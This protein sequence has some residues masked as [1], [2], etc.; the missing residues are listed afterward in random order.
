MN[1]KSKFL[2]KVVFGMTLILGACSKGT[3]GSGAGAGDS[4]LTLEASF[5]QGTNEIT[6]TIYF[7]QTLAKG[8]TIVLAYVEGAPPSDFLGNGLKSFALS[9]AAAS[10]KYRITKLGPANYSVW[11]R[12]DLNG[13]GQF[14]A[15]DLGGYYVSD[16]NLA[17]TY[18]NATLINLSTTSTSDAPIHLVT[19]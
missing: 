2:L 16:S 6:G 4:S 9:S 12:A 19:Q 1:F 14:E 18:Q 8:T 15:G 5:S 3:S 13:N 10:V 7:G 11:A 17:N